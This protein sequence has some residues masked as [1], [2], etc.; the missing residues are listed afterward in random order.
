MH[1]HV[2]VDECQSM[3]DWKLAF[4]AGWSTWKGKSS[5]WAQKRQ[6][7]ERRGR[8]K[9]YFLWY[10][11]KQFWLKWEFKKNKGV[12]SRWGC[13]RERQSKGLWRGDWCHRC[14][15]LCPRIKFYMKLDAQSFTCPYILKL[16]NMTNI[17]L[18]GDT[19]QKYVSCTSDLDRSEYSQLPSQW[20]LW[21][22]PRQN[23]MH[24]HD[25]RASR[26]VNKVHLRTRM[27]R[28]HAV[29]FSIKVVITSLVLH[30]VHLWGWK[31][32]TAHASSKTRGLYRKNGH[33][34]RGTWLAYIIKPCMS[35]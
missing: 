8:K 31:L 6:I 3:G 21:K 24:Y 32:R 1:S 23:S 30:K 29:L 11:S 15:V 27:R 17:W 20:F 16:K 4:R 34:C 2:H 19:F 9:T 35:Y 26:A 10:R 28:R 13:E 22:K 25:Y 7:G 33:G 18:N 5:A 14:C 12:N